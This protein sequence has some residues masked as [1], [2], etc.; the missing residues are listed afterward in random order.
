M[1]GLREKV[2]TGAEETKP[3]RHVFDKLEALQGRIN[4]DILQS[5]NFES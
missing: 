2:V 5:Q 4:R 1:R 3:K